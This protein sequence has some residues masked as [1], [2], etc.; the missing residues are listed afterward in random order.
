MTTEPYVR[1]IILIAISCT[2]Q[3]KFGL[4]LKKFKEDRPGAGNLRGQRRIKAEESSWGP[5]CLLEESKIANSLAFDK[6]KKKSQNAPVWIVERGL[7]AMS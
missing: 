6:L 5:V 4:L 3:N 7:D 1:G 2:G